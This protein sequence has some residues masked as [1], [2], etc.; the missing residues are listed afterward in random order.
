MGVPPARSMARSVIYLKNI[1]AMIHS[2]TA[3]PM[4]QAGI[5]TSMVEAD[6]MPPAIASNLHTPY[7]MAE[8]SQKQLGEGIENPH[9]HTAHKNHIQK[10]HRFSP[11]LQTGHSPVISCLIPF[12]NPCPAHLPGNSHDVFQYYITKMPRKGYGMAVIFH[13]P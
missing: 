9:E 8:P 10:T 1:P 13:V 6:L 4:I 12:A 3:T 2:Q 11:L 7:E 5:T